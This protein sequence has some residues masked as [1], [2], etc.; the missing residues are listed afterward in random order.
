MTRHTSSRTLADVSQH[1]TT[2]T[3]LGN[4]ARA[5]GDG[6][7]APRPG[8]GDTHADAA[9]L[10]EAHP[11]PAAASRALAEADLDAFDN[12]LDAALDDAPALD[13]GDITR[14]CII[15][16]RGRV[17]CGELVDVDS[18]DTE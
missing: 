6:T 1:D 15:T 16:E 2:T 8:V 12:A 10:S 9:A 7:A 11:A 18:D 3:H 17:E 14:A 13:G 4:A 5:V